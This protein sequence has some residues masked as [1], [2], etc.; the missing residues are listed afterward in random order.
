MST[1]TPESNLRAEVALRFRAGLPFLY[2]YVRMKG[3][4]LGRSPS[5][6]IFYTNE[7]RTAN[8][9]RHC[10]ALGIVK[11]IDFPEPQCPITKEELEQAVH[12]RRIVL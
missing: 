10:A 9:V 6:K 5:I 2:C 1:Q 11:A 4:A 12:E 3:A 8:F 7:T